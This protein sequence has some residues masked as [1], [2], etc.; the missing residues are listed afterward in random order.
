MICHVDQG[1]ALGTA[2]N[3]YF[4][5][6]G[7]GT[8]ASPWFNA[9]IYIRTP[10]ND[11]CIPGVFKAGGGAGPLSA[12]VNGNWAA[13][14][15]SRG[16]IIFVVC[17]LT[18][19]AGITND[20]CDLWVNPSPFTFNAAETNLPAADVAN[21]GAGAADVGNVDFFWIKST[22]SPFSRRFTDLRIGRTWASVTPPA[23]PTLTVNNVILGSGVTNAVFASQNVGNPVDEA[24]GGGGYQWL[25]KAQGQTNTITL[26]DDGSHI[27]GSTTATLTVSNALAGDLGTY[28]VV[29][30]STDPL[31]SYS[32]P[33][34]SPP[35]MGD[36][37]FNPTGTNWIGSASGTLTTPQSPS[38]T[39][40]YSAP[41][42]IISWP[43]NASGYLLEQTTAVA[44]SA[45]TT[46][47]LPPYPVVGANYSVTVSAASGTKFFRLKH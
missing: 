32:D 40:V 47:S 10:G 17:R 5:G 16:Q 3:D 25:F 23:P 24:C 33:F 9:A 42:V 28:T 41:N 8:P 2:G 14:T 35:V 18:I 31:N 1:S 37:V 26:T 27:T 45:W 15:F 12:G 7:T 29:G 21:A 6:F 30:T 44:P 46:N 36:R 34:A 11:T 22:A 13:Q 4:C 38:L 19:N 39:V 20:T 43:T